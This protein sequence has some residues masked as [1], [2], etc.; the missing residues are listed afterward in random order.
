VLASVFAAIV[1]AEIP[2]AF[3]F[4][5]AHLE[6]VRSQAQMQ[7]QI[8]QQNRDADRLAKQEEFRE[9]YVKE[10]LENV[11][12]QDI[13]FRIR[14]AEYFSFVSAESFRKGWTDYHDGL[15]KHRDVIR[16]DI[17]R[18]E[19]QLRVQS[20]VKGQNELDV[21]RIARNL[22]WLYKEVG[23]VEKNRSVAVN[24]RVPDVVQSA[25]NQVAA[26]TGS[27]VRDAC[28]REFEEHKNDTSD[29][30][31]A[32]AADLGVQLAGSAN[33]IV[34]DIQRQPKEWQILSNGVSA[35]E[36]A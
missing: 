4:A 17:D 34:D 28:E 27:V 10:F 8:D 15:I 11:L 12:N 6:Y 16:A 33:E 29:F 30:V 36:Y 5:T 13:E 25:T 35:A 7:M 14:F 21:E 26:S 1:I 3:Q 23:Y 24:P 32:V 22:T 20:E 18:M 19:A 2:P 31:R 9:T